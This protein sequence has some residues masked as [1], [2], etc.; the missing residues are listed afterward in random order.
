MTDSLVYD[1]EIQTWTSL[2]TQSNG[3]TYTKPVNKIKFVYSTQQIILYAPDDSVI[4]AINITNS[5]TGKYKANVKIL[6]TTTNYQSLGTGTAVS[7][8]YI[9]QDGQFIY[10]FPSSVPVVADV[11]ARDAL[12][13]TPTGGERVYRQDVTA[14]DYYSSGS[15]ATQSLGMT[16]TINLASGY[17]VIS[18]GAKALIA[19]VGQ[20]LQVFDGTSLTVPVTQPGSNSG[21]VEY[22]R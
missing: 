16:G 9:L 8:G 20:S 5:S 4:D 1:Y 7:D 21:F 19:S 12:Y 13:P 18:T 17:Y 15:W 2:G 6:N 3:Y 10:L 14:F 11:A 22:C